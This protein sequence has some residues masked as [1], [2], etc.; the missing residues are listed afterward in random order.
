M[1]RPCCT[2]IQLLLI[3]FGFSM[4]LAFY[5]SYANSAGSFSDSP[6]FCQIRTWMHWKLPGTRLFRVGWQWHGDLTFLS[7]YFLAKKFGFLKE[8]PCQSG[9]SNPRPPSPKMVALPYELLGLWYET[10]EILRFIFYILSNYAFVCK[11]RKRSEGLV[12]TTLSDLVERERSIWHVFTV[13][14]SR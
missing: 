4:L 14:K 9:E 6:G 8:L 13:S 12:T 1:C 3:C 2:C 5:Q 11:K 7:P 10:M